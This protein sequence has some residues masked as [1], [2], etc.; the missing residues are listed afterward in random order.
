MEVNPYFPVVVIPH[1]TV[2]IILQPV[3][4]AADNCG[5]GCGLNIR[6]QPLTVAEQLNN[7]RPRPLT[8]RGIGCIVSIEYICSRG[9]F[10]PF[11]SRDTASLTRVRSDTGTGLSWSS[12]G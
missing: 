9:S 5:Q 12:M 6:D 4:G 2:R 7:I 3:Q 1:R 8:Y 10:L 11:G